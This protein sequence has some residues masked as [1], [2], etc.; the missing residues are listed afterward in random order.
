MSR[1][2]LDERTKNVIWISKGIA[3]IAIVACHCCQINE[4]AS[5][6]NVAANAIMNFWIYIGVPV[7]YFFAGYFMDNDCPYRKFWKKKMVTIIIP[8]FITGTLVW[9]YVVLRK[10]GVSFENWIKFVVFK[11]SYLYFL[12]DLMIFY[13][14]TG[15]IRGGE[16]SFESC[17]WNIGFL[18]IYKFFLSN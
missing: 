1:T 2:D 7:F 3:V 10:G 17:N 13:F 12:S 6:F 16:E 15:F 11:K 8:W 14:V 4:N 18:V 9:L 5:F